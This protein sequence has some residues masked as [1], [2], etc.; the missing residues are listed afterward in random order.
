MSQILCNKQEQQVVATFSVP[1]KINRIQCI[2][3][4]LNKKWCW[5]STKILL[6]SLIWEKFLCCQNPMLLLTRISLHCSVSG[7]YE[8][9]SSINEVYWKCLWCIRLLILNSSLD[10]LLV[11][12]T[13][14]NQ[15]LSTF[16]TIHIVFSWPTWYVFKTYF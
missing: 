15:L 16:V 1:V 14:S 4:K 6:I 5:T 7:T 11:W 3:G 13:R 2:W 8:V 12:H 10:K 9:L